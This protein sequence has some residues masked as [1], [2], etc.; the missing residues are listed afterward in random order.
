MTN[1]EI[2]LAKQKY[3]ILDGALGTQMQKNGYDINDSLW[4]AK[5]LA[6]DPKA[7]EEIHLQYLEAGADCIIT[8]SYQA[9]IEGFLQKGFTKEKAKELIVLSINLAKKIRDEFWQNLKDKSN[10]GKPLVAASIG[11]YGAFLANGSEYTGEYNIPNEELKEFHKKRLEIIAKTNPDLFAVETIPSLNEAKIICELLKAFNIP[12]WISFSAKNS[13]L[14]NANDDIKECAKYLDEQKHITAL[15]INCTAP[16][17]ISSLIK[18]IKAVS[19]KPIV[20][21]PNGGSKYN[22]LTKKWESS[23]TDSKEFGK[24]ANLWKNDGASIIGGC[25]QTGPEEIKEIRRVLLC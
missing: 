16:E 23:S 11:P 20:I 12:A 22:P 18:N 9:S 5:F 25:C 19:S 10:R 6:E 21:Y 13:S 24:L 1:L 14:T 7:I 15:G 2:L 3:I 4:S 8:S 17:H